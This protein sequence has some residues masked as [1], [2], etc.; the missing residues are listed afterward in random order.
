VGGMKK[1]RKGF[2][3]VEVL[4]A[5]FILAIAFLGVGP[6]VIMTVKGNQV[7]REHINARLL[8]ERV[9]EYFRATDYEDPVLSNDG[10]NADL[11]DTLT[12]DHSTIDT[13]D[14]VVYRVL[15]NIAEDQPQVGLKTI[16]IIIK[17]RN[18]SYTLVTLKGRY[19]L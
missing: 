1:N 14:N 11:S 5:L 17:W 4:V 2:T 8:A 19:T 15:W 12:P 13:I 9:T 18:K 3:L 7:V 16:Q 10:D 6:L